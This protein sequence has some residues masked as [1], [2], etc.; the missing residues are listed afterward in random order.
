MAEAEPMPS[1]PTTPP[2][3]PR[4]WRKWIALF[5]A[6]LLVLLIIALILP[7]AASTSFGRSILVGQINRRLNGH[8]EIA[9]I[10]IGWF[11]RTRADGVVVFDNEGRQIAQ[12]PHFES[13][14]TLLGAICGRFTS[15]QADAQGLDFV[16]SRQ[17]DGTL[18][19]EHLADR[20]WR[21]SFLNL[22]GPVM[23]DH[24]RIT[25]EDRSPQNKPPAY[26][27]ADRLEM[28]PAN[29][30]GHSLP[31]FR[32]GGDVQITASTGRRDIHCEGRFPFDF[33][34]GIPIPMDR[35]TVKP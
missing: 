8:V 16:V 25:W 13:S 15:A 18:N 4:R 11:S 30:S 34:D 6:V 12:L 7:T 10:S 35:G 19:W 22:A 28:T 29:E 33:R 9:D 23:L 27:A 5:G 21:I 31:E 2:A 3:K 32:F 17:A 26:L 1:P 20:S 24:L 14:L